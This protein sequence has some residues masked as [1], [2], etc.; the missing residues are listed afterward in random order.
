MSEF[1]VMHGPQ[2]QIRTVEVEGR[3]HVALWPDML[4]ALRYKARHPELLKFWTVPLDRRLYEQEFLRPGAGRASFFLMSGAD[5][6]F[7]VARGRVIGRGEIVAGLYPE[8]LRPEEAA[9]GGSRS[10]GAGAGTAGGAAPGGGAGGEDV[11]DAEY[12]TK[13]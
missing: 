5:P 1:Y 12:T 11:V 6:G 4:S 9:W 13:G 3:E 7:E 2:G 8:W 10:A